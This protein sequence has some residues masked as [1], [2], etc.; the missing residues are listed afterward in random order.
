MKPK[1]MNR[2]AEEIGN[3]HDL[4][5]QLLL[6]LPTKSLLKFKCVS[7]QWL[8]LISDPQFC[9][10]HTRHQHRDDDR[11]L[12]PTALLLK[13]HDIFSPE[14]DVVPLK[15]YSEVPFFDYMSSSNFD[16][17]QSCNGLF[18]LES[19]EYDDTDDED[20]PVLGYFICNP[21]T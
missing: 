14:F 5:T 4:L 16:L 7:K 19:L 2:S 15:H 8:S 12:E 17:I 21:T 1:L 10:S 18:L 11:F 3:N 6:R 9:L 13:V 20:D